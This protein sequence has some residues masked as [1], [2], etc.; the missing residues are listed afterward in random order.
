MATIRRTFGIKDDVTAGGS[1]YDT[2]VNS[3]GSVVPD[4]DYFFPVTGGTLD[5]GIERI[6]RADEVR[7]RRA[8]TRA[9][10][11]RG[12]PSMTIPFPTYRN[13]LEKL[14]RKALGATDVV[15]NAA[16]LPIIHTLGALGF[17]STALPA[18]HAQMVRDDVNHKMS[19]GSI[20]KISLDFPLD[21]EGSGE[22]EIMG[23]YLGQ[24]A[25]AA[26]TATF[27]GFS[28]DVMMLRDAQAYFDGGTPVSEIQTVTI[29]GTPTGGS[30]TLTY[31]GQTTAPIAWN[32]INTAVASALNAL[33]TIGAAGVAV[34]GGPGPGTPYTVTFTSTSD[35]DML[36]PN[37]TGL[38]GGTAPVVAVTASTPS[39]GVPIADLQGF[40]FSF[41]NNLNRK[42]YAKR[43]IVT[44][45]LGT[46]ATTYKLWYPQENK[47]GTAQDVTY[48]IT[49]GNPN[50]AQ[51][52]AHEFAQIQRLVFEVVGGP[53][54]TTPIGVE[55]LRITMYNAIHTG[56]GVGGLDPRSDLTSQYD[57][58]AF[59]SESDAADIKV[60]LVN[61]T[62]TPLT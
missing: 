42:W 60:E 8:A 62:I 41:T 7:G 50:I 32:A 34:A 29:T 16:P 43:N 23:L 37:S 10:P 48:S 61:S 59:Y 9:R 21:A 1:S 13:S 58:N 52:L 47:I 2:I 19:G 44:N 25:T 27:S 36:I 3:F 24:Y 54:S 38:T 30:F 46:P 57:G 56:G 40:N 15:T 12:A 31:R 28:D 22:V 45:V 5:K 33:T 26:P 51:E 6:D 14:L 11:F 17:G 20:N 39:Y 35:P 49:L 55:L 4:A 53:L 18:F